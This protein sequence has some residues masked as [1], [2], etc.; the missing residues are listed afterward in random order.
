MEQKVAVVT[1]GTRGI[2]RA[3]V[4]RF[5]AEGFRVAFTGRSQGSVEAA[6]VAFSSHT[7]GKACDVSQPE[8]VKEFFSSAVEAMGRIDVL[9]NNAGITR[10]GL[11]LRMKPE[12]WDEVLNTNLKGAYLCCQAAARLMMK[13]P[14]GGRIINISSVVGVVGNAGQANYAAAKAGLHGLTKSLAKELASRN[15]LVNAIA[16]GFI[17][18]DMTGSL[19][20]EVKKAVLAQI[21]LA[22]FGSPQDIAAFCSFLAGPDAA[23][24][25]GQVFHVDG[26]MVM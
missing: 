21:P 16:P 26:G 23:Y 2:G 11:L 4:E 20:E 22:R 8:A 13:N 15:I 25:T 1:G 24:V 14:E 7:V 17:E 3:V 9:V 12:Q 18:T 5:L 6:Q 10:D 19:G